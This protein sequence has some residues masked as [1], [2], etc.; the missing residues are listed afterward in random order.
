MEE[1]ELFADAMPYFL[2][3]LSLREVFIFLRVSVPLR[4]NKKG[5]NLSVPAFP[6]HG[7]LR[8]VMRVV[9]CKL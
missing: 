4:E 6:H 7:A 5:R 8:E 3:E 1:D 9:M 2:P